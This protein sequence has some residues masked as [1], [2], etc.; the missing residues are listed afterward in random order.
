MKMPPN[1][2]KSANICYSGFNIRAIQIYQNIFI[3]FNLKSI[4]LS[5]R[6]HIPTGRRIN[7]A[8]PYD[9][10]TITLEVLETR[11]DKKGNNDRQILL[12]DFVVT[13]GY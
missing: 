8:E 5:K 2:P 10:F 4:K 11:S 3:E 13:G 9:I 12:G 7:N 1:K 6:L